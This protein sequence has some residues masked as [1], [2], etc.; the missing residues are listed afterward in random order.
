MAGLSRKRT[1]LAFGA[2][3][4]SPFG[5]NRSIGAGPRGIQLRCRTFAENVRRSCGASP[6]AQCSRR[7]NRRLTK[8]RGTYESEEKV[9]RLGRVHL[10]HRA[11]VR[12]PYRHRT[13]WSA[14]WLLY[15]HGIHDRL[16]RGGCE[17]FS[18]CASDRWITPTRSTNEMKR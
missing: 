2:G 7:G 5:K 13:S 16:H 6:L 18:I 15:L 10:R 1:T 14:A 12:I 9:A 4:R 3:V 11:S 8:R 17:V